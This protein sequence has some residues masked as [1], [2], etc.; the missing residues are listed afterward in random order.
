MLDQLI[1]L[2]ADVDLMKIKKEDAETACKS[3]YTLDIELESAIN[4]SALNTPKS[5]TIAS[6]TAS[7]ESAAAATGV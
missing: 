2:M 4:Q 5:A 7:K 3:Y 1:Q 6:L